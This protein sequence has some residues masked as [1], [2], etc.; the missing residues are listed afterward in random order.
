ME[1]VLVTGG[2]G[3]IGS[4]IVRHLN[5]RGYRTVNV[6]RVSDPG[7]A[8]VYIEADLT[9]AGEVYGAFARTEPDAVAHMGAIPNSGSHPDHVVFE[10]NAMGTYHV[11]EVATALGIE[12]LCMASSIQ[13]MGS[14]MP[15][16]PLAVDY[17]PVDEEHRQTP[18]DCY[19]LGKQTVEVLADGFARRPEPPRTISTFRFP[20]VLEA[21]TIRERFPEGDGTVESLSDGG[22]DVLFSYVAVGDVADLVRRAL[23]A[24]FAGHERFM[25][26]ARDTRTTVPTAELIDA[27]YPDADTRTRL[28][29]H[30]A[31]IDTGKARRLLDWEPETSWRDLHGTRS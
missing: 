30:G 9:D 29:E 2:S 25:V 18:R 27:F 31:L 28:P 12:S 14:I 7:Q 5:D 10:S 3:R 20:P 21:D 6:D 13:A 1:T 24:D 17:L 19:A 11:L 22:R 15:P 23:E 16:A 4:G 26:S 8:D